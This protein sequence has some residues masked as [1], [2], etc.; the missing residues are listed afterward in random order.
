MFRA[1]ESENE[2]KYVNVINNS[3]NQDLQSQS[4]KNLIK[5]Q[6]ESIMKRI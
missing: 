2:L 3:K 4:N 1:Y 6:I 5:S